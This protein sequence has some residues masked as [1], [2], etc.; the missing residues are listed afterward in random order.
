MKRNELILLSS[1][2]LLV[3]FYFHTRGLF[4]SDEGYI[5]NSAQR[6]LSGQIPYKDFHFAYTPLSILF[7]LISFKIFGVSMLS[8]R[9]M[10]IILSF[11]TTFIMWQIGKRLSPQKLIQFIPPL[12][13]LAWG[14]SHSNFI[15]PT[16]L[17]ISFGLL[18]CLLVLRKNFCWAGVATTLTILSKQNFGAALLVSVVV[19]FFFLKKKNTDTLKQFSKGLFLSSIFFIAYLFVTGSFQS[20]ISDMNIYTIQR[21]VTGGTLSTAFFYG[22]SPFALAKSFFYLSP[23]IVSILAFIAAFKKNKEIL[24]IFI[25]CLLFYIIGIRPTTDYIHLTPLISLIGIPLLFLIQHSKKEKPNFIFIALTLFLVFL[26]FYTGIFKQYYRWNPRLLENNFFLSDKRMRIFAFD[27]QIEGIVS[28]IK[29]KTK[30]GDYIFVTYYSPL[31]YFVSQRANPTKFDLI[32]STDFY[33]SSKKEIISDIE[34]H[35]TKII[36]SQGASI[37]E[38]YIQKNFPKVTNVCGLVIS[39]R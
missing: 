31:F 16:Q 26:G 27:S 39:E 18:T 19:F 36:V 23:L 12:L 13:Y 17:A 25:F 14:P 30:P 8:S 24:F 1:F 15:F 4:Y 6:V 9:I 34:K 37:F 32:E 29:S 21:I 38:S 2:V 28:E 3:L 35:H 20:F 33:A 22:I 10:A 11:S 7:D 5:L